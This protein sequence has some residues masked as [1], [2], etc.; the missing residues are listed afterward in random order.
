MLTIHF[1]SREKA[2]ES[3]AAECPASVHAGFRTRTSFHVPSFEVVQLQPCVPVWTPEV[4]DHTC[5][6][7]LHQR[8]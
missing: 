2:T 4:D 7:H 5:H 1:P 8:S 3:T 6:T